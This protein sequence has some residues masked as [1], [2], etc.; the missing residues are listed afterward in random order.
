V[1]RAIVPARLGGHQ[2][3]VIWQA[4]KNFESLGEALSGLTQDALISAPE[5]HQLLRLDAKLEGKR[6]A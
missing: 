2:Q 3:K 4:R 5:D 1:T 6:T